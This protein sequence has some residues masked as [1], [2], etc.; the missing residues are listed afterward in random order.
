M[1]DSETYQ[2]L[3]NAHGRRVANRAAVDS[4][5]RGQRTLS[6]F[7]ACHG[8]E[9]ML[10]TDER[11]R[12]GNPANE[13]DPTG[14]TLLYANHPSDEHSQIY[15]DTNGA[16]AY[17]FDQLRN[18]RKSWGG[19]VIRFIY[20]S[21]VRDESHEVYD[22]IADDQGD[23][24]S[25]EDHAIFCAWSKGWRGW[26]AWAASL[27]EDD[28]SALRKVFAWLRGEEFTHRWPE[29]EVPKENEQ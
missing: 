15:Q 23:F 20:R 5:P 10:S 19:W 3:L 27:S 16:S 7:Y 18:A 4:I 14:W 25:R 24:V 2:R 1:I 26:A 29:P 6:M 9:E 11:M 12:P 28:L 22:A 13:F 8:S 21:L 17:W